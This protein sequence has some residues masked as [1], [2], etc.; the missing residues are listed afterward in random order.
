M[1]VVRTVPDVLSNQMGMAYMFVSASFVNFVAVFFFFVLFMGHFF[2]FF[3][4]TE[5]ENHFRGFY[6]EGV[7]D[8]LWFAIVTVTTVGYGDKTCI[9][10]MGRLLG[11][12]WMLFGLICFGLF[13]GQVVSQLRDMQ[14]AANIQDISMLAGSTVGVLSNAFPAEL[15]SIYGFSAKEYSTIDSAAQDLKDKKVNAIVV[16]HANI[17]NYF[18]SKKQYTQQCGNPLKIVGSPLLQDKLQFGLQNALCSCNTC[19]NPQPGT[20]VFAAEYLSTALSKVIDGLEAE[21]FIAVAMDNNLI[22]AVEADS[23]AKGHGFDIF[24][25]IAMFITACTYFT[26]N[27][28]TKYPGT[29]QWAVDMNAKM[30][31]ALKEIA[32]LS[33]IK[34]RHLQYLD[35]EEMEDIHEDNFNKTEEMA[36]LSTPHPL[37]FPPSRTAAP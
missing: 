19:N 10:P 15:S 24:S 21:G 18:T 4:R 34:A 20:S 8:G 1:V 14:E 6:A 27:F 25:I 17:L 26:L 9:T 32:Y 13:G 16:P 22:P 31:G 23:C 7:M 37:L 5:N 36:R 3:E 12:F 2:W 33:G 28:L 30:I 11:A 29:K 35:R